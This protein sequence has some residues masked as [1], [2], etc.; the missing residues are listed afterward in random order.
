MKK[1][2]KT[3]GVCLLAG[4][5]ATSAMAMSV[6]A[7]NAS[8]KCTVSIG[9]NANSV[10]G[11][12]SIYKVATVTPNGG[13]F[14]YAW[15]TKFSSYSTAYNLETVVAAYANDSTEIKTLA[16]KLAMTAKDLTADA[17]GTIGNSIDLDPGYY[18]VTVTTT[19]AGIVT[20]PSLFVV[21]KEDTKTFNVKSSTITFNKTITAITNDGNVSTSGKTGIAELGATV[22]Y[23]LEADVPS[24][25][26]DVSSIDPDMSITDTPSAG[27]QF[28][29]ADTNNKVD[30]IV[31][32][33]GTVVGAANYTVS[34][35]GAG[36]SFTVT[37][38]DDWVLANGGAKVAVVADA[39]VTEA[40]VVNAA[41]TNE[42]TLTYSNQYAT[43]AGTGTISSSTSVFTTKFDVTKTFES[44]NQDNAPIAGFTLYKGTSAE[45][46]AGT[47]TAVGSEIKTDGTNNDVI[48]FSHLDAGT[49][50]LVETTV[51]TGYKKA[52]NKEVE[53][54]V[55]ADGTT[56]E[57]TAD[58]FTITDNGNI[59]ITNTEGQ[60]LPG[61]GGVGTTMFTIGGI[62]L[63]LVAG[64]MLTIYMKKRKT[65]E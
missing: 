5:I 16:D 36:G 65:A 59:A 15:T 7:L 49:Y 62:S 38:N 4:L 3:T 29:D 43:G 26:A 19:D 63:V 40:A 17:T 23:K 35:T 33:G 47:A 14:D 44:F 54:S 51:P 24:Y 57:Y 61:T 58:S 6:S 52:A 20:Q 50:T 45:Y 9:T 10:T 8:G 2:F 30:V 56:N 31:T 18:L 27:L 60:T 11:T 12:Y 1:F 37:F 39:T 21:T 28:V 42:A 25:A 41:N 53:I 64:A 48:T 55:A 34:D 32:L 22:S 46:E 13:A